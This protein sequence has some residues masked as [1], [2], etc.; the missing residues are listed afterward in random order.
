VSDT[1]DDDR[2]QLIATII[3]RGDV[4]EIEYVYPGE[5]GVAV[6]E[7]PQ[8][9]LLQEAV[10]LEAKAMTHRERF[11][12]S[13]MAKEAEEVAKAIRAV[14]A[15]R[16][17]LRA[18]VER[19]KFIANDRSGEQQYQRIEK[20]AEKAEAAL[21]EIRGIA[22]GLGAAGIAGH[23]DILGIVEI[24]LHDAAPAEQPEAGEP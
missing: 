15:E 20:R 2:A 5:E 14:L 7:T 8:E 24:A 10:R 6:S 21:R 13:V 9:V 16:D 11:H 1:P 3:Y 22:L 4:E 12:W 17:E 18:E 19:L 23:V